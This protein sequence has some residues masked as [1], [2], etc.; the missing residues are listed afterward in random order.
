M[1]RPR[2]SQRSKVYEAE[3]NFHWLLLSN[4]LER[5][6]LNIHSLRAWV[7]G[8]TSSDWWRQRYPGVHSVEVKDG[9]RRR[10]ACGW[11]EGT[12]GT[13]SLPRRSRQQSSILHE[14]AHVVINNTV[15]AHGPMFVQHYLALVDMWIGELEGAALRWFLAKNRVKWEEPA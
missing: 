11:R 8:I 3:E 15:A 9:R 2:D 7:D 1:S 4:Q 5:C 10:R 6:I 12:R 14:L 13:I